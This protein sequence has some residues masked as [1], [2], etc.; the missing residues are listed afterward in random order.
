[1]SGFTGGGGSVAGVDDLRASVA[2]NFF[3][4]A[5]D[6]GRDVIE[7]ANGRI[8]EFE[9][10]DGVDG[11]ASDG[12]EYDAAA[13]HYAFGVSEGVAGVVPDATAAPSS[14]WATVA[15][16]A[17]NRIPNDATVTHLGSIFGASY[18]VTL[19][20][21]LRNSAN[22]YTNVAEV[23]GTNG[24]S[25]VLE[26]LALASP[27]V[28]PATGDY[29]VLVRVTSGGGASRATKNSIVTG[30]GGGAISGTFSLVNEESSF[31]FGTGWKV[32][33]QDPAFLVSGAETA[34]AVPARGYGVLWVE[35]LGGAVV[36]DDF[37]MDLSRDDGD[38]WETVA[39]VERATVGGW[40]LYSGDLAYVECAAETAMRYRVW[41]GP[42]GV[43]ISAKAVSDQWGE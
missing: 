14:P 32:Q 21:V 12:V 19:A 25:G 9:S 40:T 33:S 16:E 27:F 36:N 11:A 15:I 3:M 41:T 42:G 7:I 28:V 20:I 18:D 35:N 6:H 29:Y 5:V 43:E 17:Y 2:L 22:N 34:L 23:S 26:Y 8:D 24:G 1:M 39:L 37:G 38:T 4:D 31:S 13:D 10:E 30:G